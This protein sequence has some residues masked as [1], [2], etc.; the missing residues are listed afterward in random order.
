MHGDPS[1]SINSQY[2]TEL[3][4]QDNEI[5]FIPEN[6]STDIDGFQLVIP[7]TNLG[8]GTNE[9][10]EIRVTRTF[11]NGSDSTYTTKLKAIS[12]QDSTIVSYLFY[13]AL[14]WVST[15]LNRS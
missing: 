1:L 6:P 9:D 12:F 2:E 3:V 15:P 8:R 10:V 14:G 4:I 11:S 5:R 13:R 7:V